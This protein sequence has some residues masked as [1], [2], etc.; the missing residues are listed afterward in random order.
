MRFTI[1]CLGIRVSGHRPGATLDK[2]SPAAQAPG[3]L[4]AGLASG[5]NLR[6]PM[7]RRRPLQRWLPVKVRPIGPADT[8]HGRAVLTE[9][10]SF[11]P[12]SI[13]DTGRTERRQQIYAGDLQHSE[14]DARVAALQDGDDPQAAEILREL[15]LQPPQL[16]RERWQAA[17]GEGRSDVL[18][19]LVSL[20]DDQSLQRLLGTPLH[21]SP[22]QQAL[23]QPGLVN[24]GLV[25]MIK[26]F[27]Y[28]SKKP[29]VDGPDPLTNLNGQAVFR[30]Q[31]SNHIVCRHLAR[32]QA[33]HAQ[34][35]FD[36]AA[37]RDLDAI[38]DN[39]SWENE[40]AYDAVTATA[41]E[42]CLV[43]NARFG[44]FLADQFERMQADGRPF[45]NLLLSST[46]HAMTVNLRIKEKH[47]KTVYVAKVFDPNTTTRHAR[48]ASSDLATIASRPLGHYLVGTAEQTY[49][50]EE[51]R[52]AILFGYDAEAATSAHARVTD[53]RLSGMYAETS[54][55]TMYYLLTYD[56]AS[57]LGDLGPVMQAA[58]PGHRLALL[59]AKESGGI[60][61]L[62]MAFQNGN[63][64]AIAAWA[65]W[66][67][68]VPQEQHAELLSAKNATGVPG[69]LMGLQKGHANAVA[70]WGRL[71][72]MIPKEQRAELLSA[73]NATGVPGLMMALQ[74]GRAAAVAAWGQLL[75]MIP[76]EQRAELLSAKR[77]DGVPGLMLA[78][79]NGHADA[80]AAWGRSLPLIPVEQ[81]AEL[82]SA[83]RADG[84][85]SLM[86]GLQNGHA[87]A[88]AAWG[89][90]L[91]L[92]P[93]QQRAELLLA[94]R[95][96]GLAGLVCGLEAGTA[97]SI[98]AWGDLLEMLPPTRRAEVVTTLRAETSA[99]IHQ[100]LRAPEHAHHE[101]I[102]AW[103]NI[104]GPAV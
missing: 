60:P 61:G 59:A 22:L 83:K 25:D 12:Q 35:K 82:L 80:V 92:V 62:W 38:S 19:A 94:R 37:F 39:V 24:A 76:N 26:R 100:W 65:K 4:P 55:Q 53:R 90:W 34:E 11:W 71:L 99:I 15:L 98:A 41:A 28:L 69:L 13:D 58:S 43:E 84:V 46:N 86:M 18:R 49:F 79:E 1:P 47:G 68:M 97:A 33:Q 40:A 70:A 77:A 87:N 29:G 89:R 95:A 103:E 14:L 88:V 78:L 74:N 75:D 9:L 31:P 5:E 3:D 51:P 57:N 93:E 104:F 48:V 8:E 52:A 64:D 85:P 72:D 91:P 36:Y 50:P 102:A 44:A 10:A 20:I 67:P 17:I 101:K 42:T 66:L 63:A 27:P 23:D 21:G 2:E 30:D 81:R 45:K 56:F 7:G 6:A 16:L 32:F 54:P 73:K 96:D